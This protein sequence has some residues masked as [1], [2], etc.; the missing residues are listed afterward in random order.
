[1]A[2][3]ESFEMERLTSMAAFVKA[4]E[5]ATAPLQVV[6]EDDFPLDSPRFQFAMGQ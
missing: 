3:T 1:M 4:V 2:E 5:P 6:P